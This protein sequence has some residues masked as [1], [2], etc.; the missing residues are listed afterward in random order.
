MYSKEDGVELNPFLAGIAAIQAAQGVE[1]W[2]ENERAVN[3][4][5]SISTQWRTG[6]NGPTGLDYNVLYHKMDRLEL[7]A[8]EYDALEGDVR[9]LEIE[10]LQVFNKKD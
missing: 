5:S 8:S 2:P 4:F 10:A 9:V 1:L 7:T 6:M 3:L